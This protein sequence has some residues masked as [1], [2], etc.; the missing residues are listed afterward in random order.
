MDDSRSSCR[1]SS[2]R[3]LLYELIGDSRDS[4]FPFQS[5]GQKFTQI[6]FESFRNA[7][8]RVDR[9]HPHPK[10]LRCVGSAQVIFPS[11]KCIEPH[12]F[13]IN[14]SCTT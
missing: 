13:K 9:W 2:I 5:A 4:R 3:K 8:Q 12:S 11:S 10:H 14:L 7:K 1:I 6:D